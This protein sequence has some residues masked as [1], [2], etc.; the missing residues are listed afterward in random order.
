MNTNQN[1]LAKMKNIRSFQN[2]VDPSVVDTGV[3]R[4]KV[5]EQY[6]TGM[7]P[8]C[9]VIDGWPLQSERCRRTSNVAATHRCAEWAHCM[10]Q[11]RRPRHKGGGDSL[12]H[13]VALAARAQ[14]V[15]R[16]N[17]PLLLVTLG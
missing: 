9:A 5:G 17:E 15:K 10:E 2:K 13:T 1:F 6:T 12:T 4:G 11:S 16:T 14:G 3:C 8:A 7:P